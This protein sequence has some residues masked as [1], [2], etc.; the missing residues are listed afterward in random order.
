MFKN[1]YMYSLDLTSLKKKI[2]GTDFLKKMLLKGFFYHFF[3]LS[4]SNM[5]DISYFRGFILSKI[6]IYM[7]YGFLPGQVDFFSFF[8]SKEKNNTRVSAYCVK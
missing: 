8:F 4:D 2:S 1:W 3:L 7:Y 6:N 5:F